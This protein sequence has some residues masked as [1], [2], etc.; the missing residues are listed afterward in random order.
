MNHTHWCNQPG[1]PELLNSVL[2]VLNPLQR[3]ASPKCAENG[4]SLTQALDS[5]LVAEPLYSTQRQHT[6]YFTIS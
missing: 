5:I 6:C 1:F 3:V 2:H 4:K